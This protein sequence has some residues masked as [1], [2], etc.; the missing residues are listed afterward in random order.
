MESTSWH[1]YPKVHALGHAAIADLF[2]GPVIA[3]EKIDGSQFSFGVFDGAIK[4]KSRG[5]DQTDAV[6]K[7]FQW[8][9]D[10]VELLRPNLMPD[11]TYR[12]E[13]L[14]KPKHNALCYDRIPDK[15]LIIFDINSG[16]EEYLSYE[17]KKEEADRLGLECVPILSNGGDFDADKINELLERESVLGGCKIEGVVIKNYARFGRDGKALMGKYVS[18]AFKEKHIKEWGESNPAGKNI[19]Q[20]LGEEYRHEGRWQKAIQHLKED[21]E[22]TG[23]PKDIGLLIPYVQGDID[24]ECADEIKEKLYKWAFPHI[25]R[26]AVRGLPEW[27]KQQLMESQFEDTPHA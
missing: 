18:E 9:A 7:M 14:Q 8:A 5:K 25:R 13:Y 16:H 17:A 23:T 20:I 10:T 22:F 4:M 19:L 24:V 11:W 15:H 26:V 2:D 3:E 1:S 6:D 12:A 21:G 27:Y